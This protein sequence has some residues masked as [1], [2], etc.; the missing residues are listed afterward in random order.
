MG[1][2]PVHVAV[3]ALFHFIL[4][5]Q[6]REPGDFVR[7]VQRGIVQRGDEMLRPGGPGSFQAP[8]Q[9][10]ALPVVDQLVVLAES[11]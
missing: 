1:C 3:D 4:F 7:M 8:L 5:A 10:L 2:V 11:E 6:L 9:P